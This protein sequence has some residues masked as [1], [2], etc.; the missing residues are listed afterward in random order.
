MT[1][2][3]RL[4]RRSVIS[5]SLYSIWTFWREC[6]SSGISICIISDL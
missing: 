2:F 1:A 6:G 4:E 5:I 3:R